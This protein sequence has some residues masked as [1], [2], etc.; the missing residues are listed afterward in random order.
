M[1]KKHYLAVLQG[2]VM[3]DQYPTLAHLQL[4]SSQN[5]RKLLEVNDQTNWQDQALEQG[6]RLHFTA[7]QAL[8]PQSETFDLKLAGELDALQRLTYQEYATNN[9]L[10]KRLRKFLK[11]MGVLERITS[12][13]AAY[14][15]ADDTSTPAAAISD[16]P[17]ITRAED[18]QQIQIWNGENYASRLSSD[19]LT[20][21][22]AIGEHKME[23]RPLPVDLQ[24]GQVGTGEITNTLWINAPVQEIPNDFRMCIPDRDSEMAGRGCETKLEILQYGTYFGKPV[25][26]VRLSPVS[27]RR[28][29]LR[30]HCLSL[31][32]PIGF[33]SPHDLA[34]SPSSW[35]C[36]LWLTP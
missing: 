31:G 27:G 32:H 3:P 21:L 15:S 12:E 26:K 6:L 29:Q 19:Q 34:D 30:L 5:K 8:S 35:R 10:R 17:V 11:A 28:H 18:I 16:P 20:F 24:S 33:A 22:D 25:T 1:V 2:I 7:L 9:K 4:Q 23:G 36:D 14:V 13:K